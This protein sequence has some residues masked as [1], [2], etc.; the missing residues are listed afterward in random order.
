MTI[1]TNPSKAHGFPGDDCQDTSKDDEQL[2]IVSTGEL[3]K[4]ACCR[5][6]AILL[7]DGL[8]PDCYVYV[9]AQKEAMERQAERTA[10]LN[11]WSKVVQVVTDLPDDQYKKIKFEFEDALK[12]AST[13]KEEKGER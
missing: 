9:A 6:T 12:C 1:H 7:N 2:R 13:L 4:C 11:L 3:P 5:R 10:I 8:C